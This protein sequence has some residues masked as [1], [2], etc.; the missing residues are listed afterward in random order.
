[1]QLLILQ[2]SVPTHPRAENVDLIS[3][4]GTEA[5]SLHNLNLKT[6]NPR[7]E[8]PNEALKKGHPRNP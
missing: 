1:M 4:G 5:G 6:S 7:P 8:G 2:S 3:V